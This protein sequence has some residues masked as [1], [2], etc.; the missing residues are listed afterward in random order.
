[1]NDTGADVR[2][3][4]LGPAGASAAARRRGWIAYPEYWTA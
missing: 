3:L 1:M 2:V 4:G